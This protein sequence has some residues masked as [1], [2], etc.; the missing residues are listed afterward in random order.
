GQYDVIVIDPPP[1]VGAAGS[2]LLYSREFYSAAK[3]HLR[4][5]GILQQWFPGGDLAT[6]AALA[7]PLKSR[8]LTFARLIHWRVGAS[9]TASTTL[10]ARSPSRI[11]RRLSWQHACRRVRL[12]IWWNG[13]HSTHRS[14]NLPPS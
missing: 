14:S 10:P 8:S 11:G 9:N 4:P 2:S 5:D 7:A 6:T 13:D 12:R 3:K 1:P